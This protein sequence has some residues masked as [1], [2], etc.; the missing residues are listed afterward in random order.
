MM[1]VLREEMTSQTS[2]LLQSKDEEHGAITKKKELEASERLAKAEEARQAEIAALQSTLEARTGALEKMIA[3][4]K[5]QNAQVMRLSKA[6][7]KGFLHLVTWRQ[8]CC[9]I[10]RCCRR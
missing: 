1:Q 5:E 8:S 6:T 2:R 3:D 4:L 7:P 10:W 9:D